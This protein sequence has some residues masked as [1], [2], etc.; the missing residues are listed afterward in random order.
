MKGLGPFSDEREPG[1]V[2]AAP[3]PGAG[4]DREWLESDASSE[5]MGV[6]IGSEALNSDLSA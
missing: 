1:G 4:E 2:F 3:A 6:A 5:K